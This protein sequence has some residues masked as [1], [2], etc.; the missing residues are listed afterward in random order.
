MPS[1]TGAPTGIAEKEAFL[2]VIAASAGECG[3]PV[4]AQWQAELTFAECGRALPLAW[5]LPGWLDDYRACLK[6]ALADQTPSAGAIGPFLS[7]ML[8]GRDAS[9]AQLLRALT[10]LQPFADK[11]RRI[12][13]V[14]A[15]FASIHPARSLAEA[16]GVRIVAQ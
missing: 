3:G 6:S 8:A 2:A 5:P 14:Q 4:L 11:R 7:L 1:G 9:A 16:L 13:R 12:R 10:R 15:Q